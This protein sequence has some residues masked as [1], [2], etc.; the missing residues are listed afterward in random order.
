[1]CYRTGSSRRGFTLI[2]LLVVIAIIAVLIGLLL[3]AVQKVREAGTRMQCMNNM[4]Q[5]ALAVHNYESAYQTVPALYTYIK[6]PP[7]NYSNMFFWILPYIEQQNVYVQGTTQNPVVSNGGFV[8]WS[9]D[10]TVAASIIKT[11]ICPADPTLA[12]NMDTMLN[13]VTGFASGNYR[14]N[15]MV[16]NPNG[17]GSILNAMP[18]G[19]ANTVMFAH[20]I[21]EC[22]GNGA[23]GIGGNTSTEWAAEPNDMYWGPHCIPGFGYKNFAAAYNITAGT[24]DGFQ[25][26]SKFYNT[27]PNFSFGG[28]PFQT[29][30]FQT[31]E[32]SGTCNV[33]VTV[34]THTGVMIAGLG[35]GSSRTVAAAISANTWVNACN[36]IDGTPLA[37]DW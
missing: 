8:Y 31:Q 30:P 34:S 24:I 6:G 36:P 7:K 16:F 27:L 28:I 13:N 23:G 20:A 22:D 37:S 32:G 33:E 1:M 2:E 5:V 18:D 21:K 17:P 19:T 14:G 29:M 10:P 12:G 11:Y 15:V 9:G 26:R 25:P 35:D 3:P 4:K